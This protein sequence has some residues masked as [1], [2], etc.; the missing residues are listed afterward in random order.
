MRQLLGHA[1][2]VW[3]PKEAIR[4]NVFN[5]LP[6]VFRKAGY[7]NCY[8]ILDCAEDFIEQSKSLDNQ[9]YTWSDYKHHNTIKFLAGIS[10]NGFI[11]FLSDCY[12]SRASDK[13]L[14]KYSGFYNLLERV[15][16]VMADRGFHIK[17]LLLHFCSLGVAPGAQ[18][19][20]QMTYSE[21]KKT[22]RCG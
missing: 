1:L 16:Q 7:S 19:K 9:A 22:Q 14:T 10:P 8:V 11:T 2:V 5:V 12:G 6:N 17:D 20:S 15:G 18:M 3:L 13:Y 4:Q 21:V